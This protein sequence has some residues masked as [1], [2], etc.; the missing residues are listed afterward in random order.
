MTTIKFNLASEGRTTLVVYGVAGKRVRTLVDGMMGQGDH[1]VTWNG[2]D[3]TG[4]R[5]ASGIYFYR[6]EAR[7][8]SETKRMTMI[9]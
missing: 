2:R 7:G 6:L 3:E 9:K 8:D 4:K 5:V 1:Q